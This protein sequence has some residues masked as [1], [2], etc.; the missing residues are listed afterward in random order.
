MAR[1][2]FLD[3]DG[4][5]TAAVVTAEGKPSS[6][7]TA[8]E[9]EIVPEAAP[10]CRALAEAGFLRICVTNQPE[11]ARGHLDPGELA[12]M[13]ERLQDELELDAV[14]FCPHDD[15]DDCPCR[16]PKPGMTIDAAERFGVD[17]RASYTIGDRWRDID[18]GNAAGTTA[19]LIERGYDEKLH[20]LPDHTVRGIGEAAEWI[21]G[22]E[23]QG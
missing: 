20:S 14:I 4:V 2:V 8:A 22:R 15:A 9:M 13:N 12:K 17:L 3:R 5:L 19:I 10:A 7:A 16:K 1:A 21:L 23:T 11:I 18:A 6:P